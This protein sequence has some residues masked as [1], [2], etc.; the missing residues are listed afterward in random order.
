[1]AKE[2][3]KVSQ[4]KVKTWRMCHRAYHLKYVEKLRRRRIRRPF[5]FGNIIHNML[6]ADS[7]GDDPFKTLDKMAK[8]DKKVFIQEK[9]AYGDIIGDSRTIMEHYFDYWPK[10]SL[11]F[12]RRGTKCAEHDFEVE[13][14]KG[15]VAKG[16]IDAVAKTPNKLKW[17]VENKSFKRLPNEDHR[18][19]NLQSV[20]YIRTIEMMGWWDNMAGTCWNY[21]KSKPPTVPET[22]KSGKL[23][24]RSIDT[25]PGV[26]LDTIRAN[27][28]NPKDYKELLENA[29]ASQKGFFLRIFNPVNKSVVDKVFQG[30]VDTAKEM[31]QYHG[32]KS[33]MNVDR[34]C[35]YC[36]YE[37]I[38]R[39]ELTNSDVDFV[40]EREYT[41]E[42]E[43]QEPTDEP[44]EEEDGS[45]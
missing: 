23:S 7:N 44:D 26:V 17:L 15:I 35:E 8:V 42:D 11:T 28:M 16:K 9:E 25:L 27:K 22:L 36:D 10:N 33:D 3:F 14:A 4:S 1:M 40:K 20:V 39:A 38:C 34:H 41:H 30:F 37:A 45:K 24:T 18:W 19:R 31:S 43:K 32:I 5:R 13:I 21:I 2:V 29:E 12:L 6:E